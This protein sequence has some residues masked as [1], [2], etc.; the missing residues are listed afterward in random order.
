FF[1]GEEADKFLEGA[2]AFGGVHARDL[3]LVV[4]AVA[5]LQLFF[6]LGIGLGPGLLQM[7]HELRVA[8]AGTGIAFL[9]DRYVT[10]GAYYVADVEEVGSRQSHRR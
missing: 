6:G 10:S 4:D 3:A 8:F 9:L 5:G 2:V 1:V 7:L